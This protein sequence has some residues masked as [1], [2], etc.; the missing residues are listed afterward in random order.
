MDNDVKRAFELCKP[1]RYNVKVDCG[2]VNRL[3]TEKTAD[4]IKVCSLVEKVGCETVPEAMDSA[5]FGYAGFFLLFTKAL[6]A[7]A[8]VRCSSLFLPGNNHF[9][10][11]YLRQY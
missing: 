7:P 9:F 2:G 8:Y 10:G 5:G 3:V 1:F 4:C 6:R 11:L